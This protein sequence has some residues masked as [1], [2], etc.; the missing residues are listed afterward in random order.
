MSEKIK[1]DSVIIEGRKYVLEENQVA[2]TLNG[3][4]YKIV[5]T[6]SAGVFA[7]YIESRNGQEVVMRNVRRIWYW[8][9]AASLSQL[10]M[11]GTSKPKTCKFPGPTDRIEL[12][13]AIEILDCTEK[14]RLSI[15]GVPEW[16]E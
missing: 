14:A 1:V 6:Y 11:S 16:Q 9:G 10:A 12:L 8:D 15:E 4:P 7:G 13:Q 2:K 3:L 5:R